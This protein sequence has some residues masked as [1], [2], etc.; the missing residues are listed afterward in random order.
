[1]LDYYNGIF[2]VSVTMHLFAIKKKNDAPAV[3]TFNS[4]HL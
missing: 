3:H 4:F 1:M 2:C